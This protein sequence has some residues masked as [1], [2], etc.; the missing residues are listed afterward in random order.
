MYFLKSMIHFQ[1]IEFSVLSVDAFC[2]L[3]KRTLL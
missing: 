3:N 2:L 1:I